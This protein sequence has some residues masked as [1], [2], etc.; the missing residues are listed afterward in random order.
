MEQKLWNKNQPNRPNLNQLIWLFRLLPDR[1]KV[2][3]GMAEW[4]CHRHLDQVF[5]VQWAGP[6]TQSIS[7]QSIKLKKF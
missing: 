2:F 7:E 5:P 6:R 3:G 1:P 4:F